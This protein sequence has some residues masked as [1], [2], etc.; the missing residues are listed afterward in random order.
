MEWYCNYLVC[1]GLKPPCES[2]IPVDYKY[3]LE[4]DAAPPTNLPAGHPK[5]AAA[6]TAA[7]S[8]GAS[9]HTVT[10]SKALEVAEADDAVKSGAV[11]ASSNMLLSDHFLSLLHTR[12]GLFVGDLVKDELKKTAVAN[13]EPDDL[14]T[15]PSAE[16]LVNDAVESSESKSEYDSESE[17]D[18]PEP[19]ELS[20]TPPA[21]VL[22]NDAVESD[23]ESE[24]ESES[25][26]DSDSGSIVETTVNCKRRAVDPPKT[27]RYLRSQKKKG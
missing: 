21:E 8:S 3:L 23:S 1:N 6:V 13:L 15:T 18:E 10:T 25:D 22:V 14:S 16:L 20:T 19:D 7:A 27:T 26:N 9:S 24:S 2:V 4:L 11:S 5:P 12:V 17:P